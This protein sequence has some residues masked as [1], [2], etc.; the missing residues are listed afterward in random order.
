MQLAFC[1]YVWLLCVCTC[2]GYIS[3]A[4]LHVY[5][6]DWPPSRAIHYSLR[7]LTTHEFIPSLLIM[8]AFPGLSRPEALGEGKGGANGI[9]IPAARNHGRAN[10]IRKSSM[11]AN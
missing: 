3:S 1:V 5:C 2:N 9:H 7:F 11:R 6:P 10:G 8:A 4:L